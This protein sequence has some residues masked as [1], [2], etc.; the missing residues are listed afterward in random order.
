MKEYLELYDIDR[1]RL[2]PPKIPNFEGPNRFRDTEA[3]QRENE[4]VTI[5]NKPKQYSPAQK[6]AVIP[7]EKDLSYH[8]DKV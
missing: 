2:L 5:A 1:Q 6:E 3:W 4:Y 8:S 7:F